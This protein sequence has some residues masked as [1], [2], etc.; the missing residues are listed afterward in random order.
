YFWWFSTAA[1]YGCFL[2]MSLERWFYIARPFAYGRCIGK[3]FFAVSVA[4]IWVLAGVFACATQIVGSDGGFFIEVYLL[5]VSHTVAC[6]F[7][8]AIYYHIVVITRRHI[9]AIS[10]T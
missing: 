4:S 8:F 3:L 10:K 9:E 1:N 6:C 7:I 2:A 5:P